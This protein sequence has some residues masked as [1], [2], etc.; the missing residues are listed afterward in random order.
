MI[1]RGDD[2]K[3]P[4]KILAGDTVYF[5]VGGYSVVDE[6][7][8]FIGS[9]IGHQIALDTSYGELR[10]KCTGE[11]LTERALDIV[12]IEVTKENADQRQ[13]EDD[14][15]TVFGWEEKDEVLK[16]KC[17]VLYFKARA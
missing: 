16:G 11:C 4:D 3:R 5:R 14:F 7:R 17:R 2:L 12:E 9:G 1:E 8:H 15:V 13:F 10:Y 6:V